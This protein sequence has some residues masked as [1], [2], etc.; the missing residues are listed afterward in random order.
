MF[1][2]AGIDI[3]FGTEFLSENEVLLDFKNKAIVIDNFF[4]EMPQKEDQSKHDPNKLV[5]EKSKIFSATENFEHVP[6]IYHPT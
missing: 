5:I 4:I 6:D 1:K 3:I 2:N